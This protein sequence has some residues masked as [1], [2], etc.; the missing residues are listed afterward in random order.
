MFADFISKLDDTWPD[1]VCRQH[2]AATGIM[3]ERTVANRDSA[4]SGIPGGVLIG[5]KIFYHKSNVL[6]W[7]QSYM[8]R[9]APTTS[10]EV[11][12]EHS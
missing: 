12:H 11:N 6:A 7:L 2:I 1:L 4:G 9:H 5:K 8:E 10:E 3:K